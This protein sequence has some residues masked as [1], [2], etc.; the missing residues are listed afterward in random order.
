MARSVLHSATADD[1]GK[2]IDVVIANAGLYKSRSA[3]QSAI[4]E[5]DI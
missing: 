2:R 3:A 4:D 5:G 1:E